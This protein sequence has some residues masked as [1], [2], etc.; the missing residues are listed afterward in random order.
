MM[1]CS[2][3]A[4]I[5]A[6]HGILLTV[7][8]RSCGQNSSRLFVPGAR[9][10]I[11]RGGSLYLTEEVENANIIIKN[12]S[13]FEVHVLLKDY[14]TGAF[15]EK[16]NHLSPGGSHLTTKSG[17]QSLTLSGCL[18]F[19]LWDEGMRLG[20]QMASSSA[21]AKLAFGSV[22][23]TV[24]AKLAVTGGSAFLL[25]AGAHGLVG[26]AAVCPPCA[27]VAGVFIAG[28]ALHAANVGWTAA[29]FGA[30][31]LMYMATNL[32]RNWVQRVKL[33]SKK[34]LLCT[35]EGRRFALKMDPD[36]DERK[37]AVRWEDLSDEKEQ[38]K[39]MSLE[40]L[41]AAMGDKHVFTEA[42]SPSLY[43]L[44]KSFDKSVSLLEES[45]VD[46]KNATPDASLTSRWKKALEI[47]RLQEAFFNGVEQYRS[48]DAE[49]VYYPIA[50]KNIYI[51]E[52]AFAAFVLDQTTYSFMEKTI[53]SFKGGI[54]RICGGF[55]DPEPF[56][57]QLEEPLGLRVIYV[58]N[59]YDNLAIKSRCPDQIYNEVEPG[60]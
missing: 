30:S 15:M 60:M 48:D 24:G 58:V 11:S 44:R 56:Y 41:V 59:T 20:V 2:H 32:V 57:V 36:L 34:R 27:I 52:E 28:G 14:L 10:F 21:I 49:D 1:A 9:D 29:S 4:F 25:H 37:R 35:Y 5:V 13:P 38:L 42:E 33:A 53:T 51:S 26:L 3:I 39:V 43:F 7:C 17:L 47:E 50:E 55:R 46:A 19:D 22:C 12:D 18:D 8:Y 23:K 54:A 6:A 31:S 45:A 16:R 40:H